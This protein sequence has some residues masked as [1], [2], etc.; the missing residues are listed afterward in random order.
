QDVGEVGLALRELALA[1]GDLHRLALDLDTDFPA[2]AVEGLLGA[3]L[4]RLEDGRAAL[5]RVALAGDEALGR[6]ALRA[7]DV[8]DVDEEPEPHDGLELV[9]RS[10]PS[11]AVGDRTLDLR[12]RAGLDREEPLVGER[13]HLAPLAGVEREVRDRLSVEGPEPLDDAAGTLGEEDGVVGGGADAELAALRDD[14]VALP[15]DALA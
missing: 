12:L 15:P 4:V 13:D 9:E 6:V 11:Q 14:R 7:Q 3:R 2:E 8:V 5:D 10:R 1:D